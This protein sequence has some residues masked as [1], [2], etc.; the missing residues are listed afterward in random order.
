MII[1]N[2]LLIDVGVTNVLLILVHILIIDREAVTITW[3][4]WV[5]QGSW[6]G[7]YCLQDYF[8]RPILTMLARGVV[9]GGGVA[10]HLFSPI[11]FVFKEDHYQYEFC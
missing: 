9:R 3:G 8:Y 7:T 4:V 10:V 5:C 6:M 11:R 1:L 2:V